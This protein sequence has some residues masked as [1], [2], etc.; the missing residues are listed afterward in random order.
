MLPCCVEHILLK[1]DERAIV[2]KYFKYMLPPY[3][4]TTIYGNDRRV[5]VADVNQYYYTHTSFSLVACNRLSEPFKHV[6]QQSTVLQYCTGVQYSTVRTASMHSS[7]KLPSSSGDS[8]NPKSGPSPSRSPNPGTARHTTRYVIDI[9]RS[10]RS[11]PWHAARHAKE[12]Q[13]S[14]V[15]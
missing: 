15:V 4:F 3:M 1:F 7:E 13:R 9:T 14:K 8:I 12:Q 5:A 10:G 6:S 11:D 2:T